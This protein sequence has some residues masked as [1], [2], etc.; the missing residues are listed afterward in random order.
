MIQRYEYSLHHILKMIINEDE[1]ENLETDRPV[2]ILTVKEKYNL[3]FQV[4]DII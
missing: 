3:H 1:T 4:H 2:N